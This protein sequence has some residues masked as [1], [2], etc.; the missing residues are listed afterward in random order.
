MA[1]SDYEKLDYIKEKLGESSSASGEKALVLYGSETGNAQSVATW[2]ANDL[3]NRGVPRT[4]LCA[5]DDYDFSTLEKE[6][7]IYAVVSTAG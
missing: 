1:M 4:T 5:M 7:N 6:K 3:K 2:L